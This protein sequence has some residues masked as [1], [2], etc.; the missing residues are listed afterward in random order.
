V[1]PGGLFRPGRPLSIEESTMSSF[2]TWLHECFAPARREQSPSREFR[3][4]L[5]PLSERIMPA[6]TYHGGPVLSHVDVSTV[7]YGQNW[8][9]S[10]A[11]GLGRYQLDK[12]LSDITGSPY[13]AML[14]E[15]GVGRGQFDKYD[16]VTDSS[17]PS[18]TGTVT[19]KESQI[20]GML[21]REILGGKLPY[22]R[23]QQLYIVYLAPNVKSQFDQVSSFNKTGSYG[24]HG[25]FQLPFLNTVVYYS[26]IQDSSQPSGP[27]SGLNRFQYLTE[28]TSHELAEAATDP[29]VRLTDTGNSGGGNSAWW[30]SDQYIYLYY[31]V[32]NPNYQKEIG[33]IVNLQYA[34]FVANGTT[35]TVQKEWSNYWG[36]GILVNGSQ[37]WRMNAGPDYFSYEN[38]TSWNNGGYTAHEYY[39]TGTDGRTYLTFVTDTGALSGWYTLNG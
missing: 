38:S 18:A 24:H 20:Q 5:E 12:Y 14:G 1:S 15:Y 9:N 16:D 25:S 19:V 37:G 36:R 22:E 23:G 21:T 29:D 30:D 17:S 39:G 32:P 27:I 7:F 4:T 10:D 28:V 31:A 33:D 34:N 13:M 11:W 2:F 26:V 8:K 3:P 35:Y 6:I